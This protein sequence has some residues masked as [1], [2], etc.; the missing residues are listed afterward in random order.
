MRIAVLITC[1]ERRETTLRA[2]RAVTAQ[3]VEAEVVPIVVDAASADGTAQAVRQ[4]FPNAVV[5]EVGPDVYWNGGMHRAWTV[6]RDLGFDHHV[7]LNDDTTIDPGALDVLL[8][9]E[10]DLRSR[11]GT[12]VVVVGSTR[13]PDTGV[14]TYGGV[15]RPNPRRPLKYELVPPGAEPV[16]CETMNGNLVLVPDDVVDRVGLL[17]P[18]YTHGMGDYDYGHRAGERGIP[19]WVAPGTL[20]TCSRN[21]P[22]AGDRSLREE[23][24]AVRRP[25]GLPPRD[26]ARYARAWAGP[27]WPVYWLS[28]YVRRL[29]RRA[30][31]TR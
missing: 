20:G 19:C 29:L 3:G 1:H 2:L 11:L 14:L 23:W 15:R 4:E 6:A 22:E 12:G 17:D 25:T 30:R 21:A 24:Q 5:V 31:P 13:D 10:A 28:P 18:G 9:T 27:F 16:P 7:W 8:R 26:F